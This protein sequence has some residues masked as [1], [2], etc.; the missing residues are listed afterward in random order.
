MSNIYMIPDVFRNNESW[1][2]WPACQPVLII[3]FS[4]H[5]EINGK[6][7]KYTLIGCIRGLA[8]T[9]SIGEVFRFNNPNTYTQYNTFR[10]AFLRER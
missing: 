8:P 6:M 5:I 2:C 4:F 1:W 3:A 10:G 7:G 9:K